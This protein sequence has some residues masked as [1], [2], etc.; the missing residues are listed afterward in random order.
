MCLD[1]NVIYDK[2]RQLV[3]M[4]VGAMVCEFEPR[5]NHMSIVAGRYLPMVGATFLVSAYTPVGGDHGGG[6]GPVVGELC[7]TCDV[8]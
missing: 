2:F 8:V 3:A 5:I 1:A 6:D 4:R 7:D